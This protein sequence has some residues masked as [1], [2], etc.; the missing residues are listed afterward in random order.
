MRYKACSNAQK[1][2]LKPTRKIK[3]FFFFSAKN[4]KTIRKRKTHNNYRKHDGLQIVLAM[5]YHYFYLFASST[6][7]FL[8]AGIDREFQHTASCPMMPFQYLSLWKSCY[9]SFYRKKK[10]RTNDGSCPAAMK[11]LAIN[12]RTEIANRIMPKIYG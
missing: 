9:N 1:Y 10:R 6:L 3:V 11:Y 2:E 4:Q 5:V 12:K 8:E 7:G